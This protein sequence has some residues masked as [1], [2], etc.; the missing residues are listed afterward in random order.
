LPSPA[1]PLAQRRVPRI[2]DHQAIG[3]RGDE[4]IGQPTDIV[5]VLYG[6]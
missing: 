5:S 4:E 1:T 3:A 6:G 2:G